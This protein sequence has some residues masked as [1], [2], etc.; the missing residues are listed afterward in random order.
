M[1]LKIGP[2]SPL[3]PVAAETSATTARE[4]GASRATASVAAPA[5]D[6]ATLSAAGAKISELAGSADFDQAKVDA[7]RLAIREGRFSVNAEAI[8]D[9]LIYEASAL[10]GGPRTH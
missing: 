3:P 6:R 4:T 8:A 2:N 7:I 9:R 10:V 1:T 5:Q